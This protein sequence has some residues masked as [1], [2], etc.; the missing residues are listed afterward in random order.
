MNKMEKILI[1][2]RS[3]KEIPLLEVVLEQK[4]SLA[5]PTVFFYH[6]W[7]SQKELVL[8]QARALARHGFR[9]I[10]PDALFH[11]ERKGPVSIIPSLTFWQSIQAN[12]AEFSFLVDHFEKKG[13][14]LNHRIGVSGVSMGGFTT[15]MLITQHKE[16]QAAACLMGS[17]TPQRYLKRIATHAVQQKVF[18][19]TDFYDLFSWISHYDLSVQ[20]EKIHHRPF[21]IWH[22]THDKRVPYLPMKDFY[23]RIQHQPYASH[24]YFVTGTKKGHLIEKN[25]MEDVTLFFNHY[26]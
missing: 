6:G 3:I 23:Q 9:V 16:I 15:T 4:R 14:I 11:G 8:T 5:L 7:R 12:L 1:L 24:T 26:L 19:P 17:A 13:A 20:A 18:L 25:T 21:Y 22:G 2:R 10:C